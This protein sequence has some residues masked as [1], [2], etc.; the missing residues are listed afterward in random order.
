M[1][2]G[3]GCGARGLEET[4]L[5]RS[6]GAG[7]P[8]GGTMTSREELADGARYS[9]ERLDQPPEARPGTVK[10]PRWSA[11]GRR[12]LRSQGETAHRKVRNRK[13]ASRRSIP[14]ALARGR[15]ACPRGG[16]EEGRP[17]RAF[18]NRG[19]DARPRMNQP[20][21]V[22]SQSGAKRGAGLAKPL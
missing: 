8:P 11:A 18:E 3:E 12:F 6:G 13:S 7:A 15:K 9:A 4:H 19:D 22:P 2:V 21:L 10:T 1:E 14:S 16:G 5:E 20:K 17:P